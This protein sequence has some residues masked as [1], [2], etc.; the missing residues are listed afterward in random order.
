[1]PPKIN[2]LNGFDEEL[3]I[4]FIFLNILEILVNKY[5]FVK[6]NIKCFKNSFIFYI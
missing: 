6:Y 1:V 5:F 4:K 2:V 3:L